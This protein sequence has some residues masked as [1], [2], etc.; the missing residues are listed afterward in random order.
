MPLKRVDHIGV[1]V[2]GFGEPEG[3]LE[4]LGLRRG[5]TNRNDESLAHH[6]P[7]GDVSIELIEVHDP[8]ARRLRLPEGATAVIEHIA[9]EVDDL[10]EVR[11]ILAARGVDV[12]WPPVPSGDALMIWTDAVTSGGVEYQFLRRPPAGGD[13]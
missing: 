5:R 8:Q 4:A 7:C 1:G 9:I 12:T 3:L 6:F 13:G 2:E 11:R 10:E